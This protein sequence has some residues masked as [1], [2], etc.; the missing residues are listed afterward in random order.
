V[1]H[2]FLRICEYV[3]LAVLALAAVAF[4]AWLCFRNYDWERGG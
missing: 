4:I 2:A 1:T 3:G